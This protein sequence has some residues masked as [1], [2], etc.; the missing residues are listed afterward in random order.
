MNLVYLCLYQCNKEQSQY[1]AECNAG[2]LEFLGY[3]SHASMVI[4]NSFHGTVFSL[5]LESDN[6]FAHI[7]SS[8]EVL[9]HEL[10][11]EVMA[12]SA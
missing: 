9:I 8:M 1:Y 4:T 5:L 7:P 6:V 12:S 11:R 10:K 3:I 2:P